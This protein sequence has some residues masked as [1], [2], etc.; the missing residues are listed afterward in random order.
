[1]PPAG[2]QSEI[3]LALVRKSSAFVEVLKL[4]G[5]DMTLPRRKF[6]HLTA[7]AAALPAA[8]WIARAQSYPSRPVHLIEGFGPGSAPDIIARLMAQRLSERLGQAFVVDGRPGASGTIATEAV[9]RA[10]PDGYTL[11]LVLASNAINGSLYE[12]LDFDFIRD[13]APV[14]GIA[15]GPFVMEVNPSVPA[16]TLPEFIAYARANPGKVNMGSAGTGDLTQISGELFKMLTGINL[17]EVPYRGVEVIT[18]LISGEVQV[19][20][21][22][23]VSSIAHIK[24]GR[25]RALA[26][27]TATRSPAL[28]D[29]PT[30]GEF[31]PGYEASAWQG[32]GVPKNTPT[33]IVQ[34]LNGEINATLAE[35]EMRARLA[36]LGEVP[37]EMTAAEFAKLIVDETNKWRKVIRTAG[38]KAG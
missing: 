36:N 10:A 21:G 13:I 1:M 7:G 22:P 12:H 18:G 38:I 34:K 14:A 20:F 35:P 31:V 5:N 6:L 8:S 28:P 27:T 11:L 37:L 15:R 29:I 23:L 25:L 16:K 19:Y 24:A 17:F 4:V 32:I 2:E 30:V 33:A 3:R 9:V 26:V